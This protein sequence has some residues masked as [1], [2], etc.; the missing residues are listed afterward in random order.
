MTKKRIEKLSNFFYNSN[1]TKYI[2]LRISCI[3]GEW[4]GFNLSKHGFGELMF[5]LSNSKNLK[6][7]LE[8]FVSRYYNG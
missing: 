3:T 4:S 5:I 2:P 7:E 1:S 6:K 8:D